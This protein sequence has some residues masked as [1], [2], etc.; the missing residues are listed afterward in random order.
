MPELE[1]PPPEPGIG[2]AYVLGIV[3]AAVVAAL[4]FAYGLWGLK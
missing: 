1:V 4:A 3:L 2:R